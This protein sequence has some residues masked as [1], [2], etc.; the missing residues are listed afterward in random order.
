MQCCLLARLLAC[1]TACCLTRVSLPRFVF[2]A[3]CRYLAGASAGERSALLSAAL[4]IASKLLL[5]VE[6]FGDFSYAL[7][8]S[9]GVCVYVCV[10][11]LVC[12]WAASLVCPPPLQLLC[13]QC[14]KAHVCL[15]ICLFVCLLAVVT[16]DTRRAVGAQ[17]GCQDVKLVL[18]PHSPPPYKL[19]SGFVDMF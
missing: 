11:V 1:H 18:L 9:Q 5:A 7:K 6:P 4:N 19:L 16:G 2:Y 3:G 13:E 14:D 12:K 10:C 8:R 15:F 17:G